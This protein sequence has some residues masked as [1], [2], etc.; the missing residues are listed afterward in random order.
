MGTNFRTMA[1]YL[2]RGMEARWKGAV[3]S[4]ADGWAPICAAPPLV[5]MASFATVTA[6]TQQNRTEAQTSVPAGICHELL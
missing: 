6:D 2:M 5:V 1:L 4:G 3:V